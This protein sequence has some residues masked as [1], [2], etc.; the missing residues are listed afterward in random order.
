[1]YL[2][3]D[4]TLVAGPGLKALAPEEGAC[5][6]LETMRAVMWKASAA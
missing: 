3:L 6:G 1:M 2:S 4:S 5:L